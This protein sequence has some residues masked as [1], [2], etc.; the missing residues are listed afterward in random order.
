MASPVLLVTLVRRILV[1]VSLPALLMHV[2]LAIRLALVRRPCRVRSKAAG[3]RLAGGIEG[4]FAAIGLS[5][6]L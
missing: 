2:A 3:Q 1:D 6:S 5:S 4:G